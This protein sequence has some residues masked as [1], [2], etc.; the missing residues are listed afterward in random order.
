MSKFIL[1]SVCD[2]E[3]MTEVFDSYEEARAQRNKE[4]VEWAHVPEDVFWD[5]EEEYEDDGFAYGKY[6]A[7]A[8]GRC[9]FDWLIV[10]IPTDKTEE[11]HVPQIQE[12]VWYDAGKAS[13]E[14]FMTEDEATEGD[15][16]IRY[17]YGFWK[18]DGKIFYEIETDFANRVHLE[19]KGWCWSV[20]GER[21]FRSIDDPPHY[22][23]VK[24]M[25]I[26]DPDVEIPME[27]NNA[28]NR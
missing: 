21:D 6:E 28:E 13:P 8:N 2:R 12:G 24:W 7:Y 5:G 10:E 9:D 26:P 15:Y 18:K 14:D 4:M 16:L 17:E 19:E 23:V 3:I 22:Y 1:I 11:T 25:N 27:V 20:D